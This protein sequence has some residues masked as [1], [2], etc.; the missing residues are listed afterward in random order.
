VNLH[1]GNSANLAGYP[2]TNPKIYF[3]VYILNQIKKASNKIGTQKRNDQLLSL[4]IEQS[5]LGSMH[6]K[7]NLA[8]YPP[9]NPKIYFCV[10]ILNHNPILEYG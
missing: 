7:I 2:P 8:G 9:T 4:G 1:I 10:Y 6:P 3:C 5:S